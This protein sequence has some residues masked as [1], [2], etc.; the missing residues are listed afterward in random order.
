MDE[1]TMSAEERLKQLN[2]ERKTL[3]VQVKDERTKRLEAEAKMR[4][5][6]DEKI[7]K[8]QIKLKKISEEIYKYNKL[9]KVE[10]MNVNILIDI[11][12]E[13][14][15]EDAAEETVDSEEN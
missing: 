15:D 8:I 11:R 9:G 6:R 1:Q 13:C 3:R 14:H 5:V 2:K 12:A 7:E 4:V 10:K